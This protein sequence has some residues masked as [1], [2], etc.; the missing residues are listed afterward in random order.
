MKIT[1]EG[2]RKGKRINKSCSI[3]EADGYLI[4]DLVEHRRD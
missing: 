2:I 4:Q 1:I 3:N